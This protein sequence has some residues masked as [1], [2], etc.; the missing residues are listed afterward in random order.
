MDQGAGIGVFQPVRYIDGSPARQLEQASGCIP[1]EQSNVRSSKEGSAFPACSRDVRR[2]VDSRDVRMT[3]GPIRAPKLDA[4]ARS[5]RWAYLI[6]QLM[7][8]DSSKLTS[9]KCLARLA[10][11]ALRVEEDRAKLP[12]TM[13]GCPIC[14]GGFIE[15]NQNRAP[16]RPT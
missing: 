14:M 15:T 8:L 7:L 3:N 11:I 1:E 12:A 10:S 4:R 16:D 5:D 2:G 9:G 6:N 13:F